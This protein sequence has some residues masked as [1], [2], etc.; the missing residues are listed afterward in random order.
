MLIAAIDRQKLGFS[1][2]LLHEHKS[3][4]HGFRVLIHMAATEL[5]PAMALLSFFAGRV[6]QGW[7]VLGSR[8]TLYSSM[9][10]Q[11]I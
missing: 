7:L 6:I 11:T 3:I 9:E 10:S 1:W 4:L 2:P 8:L 5:C